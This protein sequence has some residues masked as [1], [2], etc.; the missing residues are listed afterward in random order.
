MRMNE[1]QIEIEVERR[2]DRLDAALM[3]GNIDQDAYD[4]E[5]EKIDLWAE[6]QYRLASESRKKIWH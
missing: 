1:T 3:R 6:A 2:F 5:V 4:V